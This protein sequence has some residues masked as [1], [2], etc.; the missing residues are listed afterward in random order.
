MG[1]AS[2]AIFEEREPVEYRRDGNTVETGKHT[3][4]S[5]DT[6]IVE[7]GFYCCEHV[8]N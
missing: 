7:R 5:Q 6:D 2:V 8:A 4:I 3:L 1:A